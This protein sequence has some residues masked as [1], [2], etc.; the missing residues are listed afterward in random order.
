MD[1]LSDVVSTVRTGHPRSARVEWYAPWGMRFTGS[2]PPGSGFHVILQGSCRLFMDGRPSIPLGPGDVVFLPRG[3]E[4][5]LASGPDVSP[6]DLGCVDFLRRRD[7]LLSPEPGEPVPNLVCSERLPQPFQRFGAAT[8]GALGKEGASELSC[9]TVSG[10][11]HSGGARP[12]PLLADLPSVVHLAARPD[13]RSELP[14]AVGLLGRELGSQRPGADTLV[15]HLLD[16]MLVYILRTHLEE[17]TG[18][19]GEGRGF[20]GALRDPAV[21]AALRAVHLDP[22]HPWTVEGLGERAG[23]SRAAFS[24]RFGSLVGMPP[25][26]YVTWWRLTLAA[27]LLRETDT[28]IDTIAA[29]AGYASRFAFAGAFKREFGVPP[30]RYREEEHEE[31]PSPGS[32][33]AQA[34]AT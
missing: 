11:Y 17:C 3:D 23:L 31:A 19:E 30:A 22:A 32:P 26:T 1:V 24:R 4:H 15:P 7:G 10:F 18:E 21:H 12:H 13:R 6:S 14:L 2:E 25:L 20:T 34:S 8:S 29:R 33:A 28:S 5:S 16:M 9:V 27:R